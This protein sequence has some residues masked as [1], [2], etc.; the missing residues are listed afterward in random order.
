ML[1]KNFPFKTSDEHCGKVIDEYKDITVI[2]CENCGYKHV[3]PIPEQHDLDKFYEKEFRHVDSNYFKR[4]EEDLEWLLMTYERYYDLF[5]QQCQGNSKKLLEIGSGSGHFLKC[6]KDRNWD[7]MGFEPSNISYDYSKTLDVN[8]IHG[9]FDLEKAKEYG[10]YD[11]IFMRNVIEHISNPI[12]ML[13]D[14][15]TLLNSNGLLFIVSPNDYNPLQDI[16]KKKLGFDSFWIAKEHINYFNFESMKNLLK[17]L[18]LIVI[19]TSATFPMEFFLLSGQDYVSNPVLG[20]K[21]HDMRKKFETSLD[22]T[23]LL[24]SFYKFSADQDIGRH[25]III[26]RNK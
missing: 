12:A 20:R 13:K 3:F 1:N 15:K 18:D 4:L 6:G 19:K 8:V 5:E 7:V 9:N 10:K 11:V 17:K 23:D 16:L 25:F 14:V 24:D 26:A 22:E 21:C 2:D